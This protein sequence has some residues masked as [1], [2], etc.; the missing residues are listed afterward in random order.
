MRLLLD[1][2]L[3]RR[4]R[5]HLAEHDVQTAREMNWEELENGALLRAAA[6]AGFDTFVSIDK[7]LEHE[8]NLLQL[9]IAVIVLD[10][11]SN[12]LPDLLPLVSLLQE[13]LTAPLERILYVVQLTGGIRK[14]GSSSVE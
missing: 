13:L 12:A 14:V 3:P 2:N 6:E 11:R 5:S 1:H 8:Q 4:L 7:K 10:A 9:P